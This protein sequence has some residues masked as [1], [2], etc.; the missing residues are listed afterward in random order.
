MIPL[1]VILRGSFGEWLDSHVECNTGIH[2]LTLFR[3]QK[4]QL[5]RSAGVVRVAFA[6]VS[7]LKNYTDAVELLHQ[8]LDD[9]NQKSIVN[10]SP[11]R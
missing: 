7:V 3:S 2:R 5:I 8:D 1:D 10:S 9:Y 6:I 11:L 4:P